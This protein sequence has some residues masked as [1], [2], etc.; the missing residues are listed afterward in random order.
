MLR[1]NTTEV[2]T[3]L[4]VL[5]VAFGFL[6][7]ALAHSGQNRI[8]AGYTLYARFNN[9][10]GLNVGAPV[11]LA[12]VQVGRVDSEDVD[13]KTYLANVRMTIRRGIELPTDSSV[14][15]SSESLLG[16]E[17][18][19]IEPGADESTL[20]PGQTITITQGAVSLEDLLGKFI[21]S[22]TNMVSAIGST[23][24][25]P[26]GTAATPAS[27][28]GTAATPAAPGAPAAP[29]GSGAPA[30]PK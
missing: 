29:V 1:R 28:N 2:L 12:G 11:R 16:G 15:V 10:A 22:A 6:A 30:G 27:P 19:S 25:S 13:Q 20:K 3:G 5:V 14:T 17:Y 8:G 21:F 7:Y 18:L 26:G 9:V 24:A 4:L 23:K